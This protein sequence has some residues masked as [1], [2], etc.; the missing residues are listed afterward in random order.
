MSKRITLRDVAAQI[1]V[2]TATASLALRDSP[3]LPA[4][5][6]ERVRKAAL[7]LGYQFD[8]MLAAL[9]AHRW[10]RQPT[11]LGSTLAVLADGL[12]EGEQGMRERAAAQGYG[13][14]V[15]QIR[16]YPDPQRLADVLHSRGILGVIVAQIFKP[17]FCAA[18]DW[19]RFIAVACSEGYER[20]PVNLVMPNHFKAVQDAWDRARAAG[21]R[22]IGLALYNMPLAIDYHERYAAFLERQRQV[23]DSQRIPLCV[24]DPPGADPK[25][26][27]AMV[28]EMGKW[29]Q[30][31]KPEVVLGFNNYFYWILRDAGWQAPKKVTFY[32]LWITET[33][34]INPGFFLS[35]AELGR[36]AVELLDTLIRG[37]ERGIPDHPATLSINFAWR[38]GPANPVAKAKRPRIKGHKLLS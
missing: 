35:H 3:K 4:A 8:P 10:N 31:W 13:L 9:S 20:P 23:S 19:S 22:R 37:G 21:Y 16:D 36:R 2:S 38:D 33:P 5:T 7:D 24:L 11:H 18:F 27:L 1:G 30:E 26:H 25:F 17:G 28:R 12:V 15:F 14:E 29:M 34:I 32:D 6:R